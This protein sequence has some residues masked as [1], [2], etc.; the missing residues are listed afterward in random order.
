MC[1]GVEHKN[2][3]LAQS[4]NLGIWRFVTKPLRLM[5]DEQGE[6]HGPSLVVLVCVIGRDWEDMS[7][8]VRV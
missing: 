1:L 3:E 2:T 6:G 4:W 8:E 5:G 7:E